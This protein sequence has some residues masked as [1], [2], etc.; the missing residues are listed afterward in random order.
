MAKLIKVDG[1]EEELDVSQFQLADYQKAVGGYIEVVWLN[2]GDLMIVDEEGKL[3]D[4]EMNVKASVL[5]GS[6]YDVIVGDVIV[7]T[8]KEFEVEP[9]EVPPDMEKV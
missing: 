3:K 1:T 8:R 6:S 2:N 5:Y 9:E 4:K 7:C